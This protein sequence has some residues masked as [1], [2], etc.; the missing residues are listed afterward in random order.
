M[1][2]IWC[3]IYALWIAFIGLK[4]SNFSPTTAHRIYYI[5]W[6]NLSTEL[7]D[8]SQ[9]RHTIVSANKF[10]QG[11][12]MVIYQIITTNTRCRIEYNTY[13]YVS[14]IIWLCG[15]VLMHKIILL[16]LF[17][18]CILNW[19]HGEHIESSSVNSAHLF[20]HFIKYQPWCVDYKCPHSS[21]NSFV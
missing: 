17:S 10:A 9:P 11:M 20:Q 6:V 14:S 15:I 2:K 16:C 7:F 4:H 5:P 13:V 18:V 19:I 12:L 3:H 8:F 21:G 1:I